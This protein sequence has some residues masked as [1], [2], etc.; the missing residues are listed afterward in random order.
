MT[1]QWLAEPLNE[2]GVSERQFTII[3][4]SG[5]IPGILWT[6]MEHDRP[7]PLVLIGHG[8]SGHKRTDRQLM[9]ARRLASVSQMAVVT[10]DGPFHGD[11]VAEP[12]GRSGYQAML[13]AAGVD[14]VVDGMVD[15]WRVTLDTLSALDAIDADRIAYMGFSMG[16]RFGLPYVAA[17]GDRLRCAVLGKNGMQQTANMPAGVDMAPRFAQDA[18]E[19]QLPILFHVQW[20]DELFQRDGQFELFDLLGTSDKRMIAFPGPHSISTPE[21]VQGWCAFIEQRLAS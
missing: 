10:I 7:M 5:V 12:L 20:D 11:R 16:T 19:I 3:R 17:A 6:P 13:A 9:L 14:K 18:P 15:D 2:G 8:G 21:A 4:E 1:L